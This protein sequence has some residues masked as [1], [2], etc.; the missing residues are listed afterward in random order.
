MVLRQYGLG[1]HG[2]AA[3]NEWH[4]RVFDSGGQR[5]YLLQDAAPYG[6]LEYLINAFA[7]LV[8]SICVLGAF[9]IGRKVASHVIAP[10]TQLADAVQ[11]G[12]KPF[13][14]R[15]HATRSV[16][17]P[18]PLPGT[19]MNW[20]VSFTASNASAAMPAMSCVRR[21]PSSAALRKP[22]PASFL[23]TAIWFPA[24]SAS[25]V[26]PRR[27]SASC[28]ACCCSHVPRLSP[29][30]RG[31]FASVDRVLRGRCQPW[32]AG[33]P[34][35]I[36]VD[37]GREV[38]MHTSPDLVHSVIWNLTRNACQY[39][40]QGKVRIT[41]DTALI[42]ADTGPGLPS[43]IDPQQFQRFVPGVPHSGE[44]LGLSIVQRIVEHLGWTMTVQSSERGCRFAPALACGPHLTYS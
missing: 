20:S 18:A 38:T 44:G 2:E 22:L 32:L 21:W 29:A 28:P 35:G 40:E 36:T 13:P 3:P 26:P 12:R 43:S 27:C 42:I 9:L 5:Y 17:W 1:Y 15:T 4:L 25:C 33:K 31:G 6:Y 11:S 19:V 39:T 8:I 30:Q 7:A 24:R 14:A 23:L 16:F 41:L 10:I 34:V 37:P